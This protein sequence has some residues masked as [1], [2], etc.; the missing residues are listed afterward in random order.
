MIRASLLRSIIYWY[1]GPRRRDRSVAVKG[2]EQAATICPQQTA[3]KKAGYEYY[4]YE[5]ILYKLQEKKQQ[6]GQASEV[7]PAQA[8]ATDVAPT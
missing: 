3:T 7:D 5:Y 1:R 2:I 8:T 4:V 6:N